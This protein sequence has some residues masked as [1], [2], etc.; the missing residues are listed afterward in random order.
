MSTPPA[1]DRLIDAAEAA[2]RASG[3]CLDSMGRPHPWPMDLIGTPRV[4]EYLKPFSAVEIEQACEFLVRMGF[5]EPPRRAK[6][7]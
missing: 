4:P 6:K 2:L 7:M 1:Y 5:L 3:E